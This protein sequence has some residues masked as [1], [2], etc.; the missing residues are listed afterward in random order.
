MER[1]SLDTFDEFAE[2]AVLTSP[3]SVEACRR[4]GISPEELLYKWVYNLKKKNDKW[5]VWYLLYCVQSIN[6]RPLEDFNEPGQDHVVVEKRYHH[7]EARRKRE[8]FL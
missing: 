6:T 4:E 2:K 5:N 1:V 8:Y 7:Y 3:R